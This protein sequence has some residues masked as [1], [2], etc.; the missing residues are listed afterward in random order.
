MQTIL[1]EKEQM[2]QEYQESMKRKAKLELDIKDL[3][4][5]VEGDKSAKVSQQD[6]LGHLVT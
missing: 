3:Q 4:D 1:D 2:T 5:D 6:Q